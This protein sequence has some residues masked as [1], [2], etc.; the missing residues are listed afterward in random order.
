[1]ATNSQKRRK[2]YR[3]VN[4]VGPSTVMI[5]VGQVH[6]IPFVNSVFS[7][8]KRIM[9]PLKL[10]DAFV[11]SV[12]FY[13]NQVQKNLNFFLAWY[14]NTVWREKGKIFFLAPQFLW[15]SKKTN[16]KKSARWWNISR[17]ACATFAA[18]REMCRNYHQR[19]CVFMAALV[20][21]SA[22]RCSFGLKGTQS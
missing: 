7:I 13:T 5:L 19:M 20:F 14:W 1:M 21:W 4:K 17:D 12:E 2:K 10:L 22:D 3:K 16:K 6:C 8:N 15:S 18:F 11:V 9:S